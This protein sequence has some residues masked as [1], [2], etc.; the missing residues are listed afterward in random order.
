MNDLPD[1]IEQVA[2]RARL[3]E[4]EVSSVANEVIRRLRRRE[5]SPLVWLSAGAVLTAVLVLF[6]VGLSPLDQDAL[7]LLFEE[8]RIMVENGGS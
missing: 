6:F 2:A 1:R 5:R 3:H 4:P 7:D 8:A